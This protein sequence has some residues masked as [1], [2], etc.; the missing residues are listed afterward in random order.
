MPSSDA[1]QTSTISFLISNKKTRLLVIDGYIYQQNKSTAKVSYWLCEIELCNAGVYLNSDDQ[2]LKYAE[3]P[4]TH[5]PVPERLEIS[6]DVD[7]FNLSPCSFYNSNIH[8]NQ[9]HSS[10]TEHGTYSCNK[11]KIIKKS[12]STCARKYVSASKKQP[13]T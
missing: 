2:F 8:D 9:Q 12:T 1:D 13:E 5:I 7:K 4:H 6:Q 10:T 3:N 11:P